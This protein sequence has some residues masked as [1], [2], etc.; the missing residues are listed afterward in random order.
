M[1]APAW[2]CECERSHIKVG[3]Q[4]QCCH[5]FFPFSFALCGTLI[6]VKMV[7][8]LWFCVCTVVATFFLALSLSSVPS[9]EGVC[10]S[11]ACVSV[12]VGEEKQALF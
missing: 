4:R 12:G 7:I 11:F 6:F 5:F 2:M 3:A 8:K 10:F 9:C 1:R